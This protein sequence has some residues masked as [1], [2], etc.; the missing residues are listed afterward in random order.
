MKKTTKIFSSIA[1]LIYLISG[2][3]TNVPLNPMFLEEENKVVGIALVDF[4]S[5]AAH[6]YGDGGVLDILVNEALAIPLQQYLNQ[7]DIST[8]AE[9]QDKMQIKLETMNMDVIKIN[10]LI[11]VREL[12]EIEGSNDTDYSS[13]KEQYNIDYLLLISIHRIGTI[14][15]YALGVMPQGSP[16]AI[17]Q[18]NGQ[19]INLDTNE[20]YWKY[21]MGEGESVV[22]PGQTMEYSS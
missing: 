4:P 18:A 6:K 20:V 13:L 22:E 11:N 9:V 21:N 7:Y 15:K 10:E 16:D 17:C 14:R 12:P 3:A 1:I 5:V 2:C 8:F 19:L